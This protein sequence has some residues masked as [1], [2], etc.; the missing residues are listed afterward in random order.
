MLKA[1]LWS[2]TFYKLWLWGRVVPLALIPH[3]LTSNFFFNKFISKYKTCSYMCFAPAF[4]L[5]SCLINLTNIFKSLDEHL[6]RN[7]EIH[8]IKFDVCISHIFKACSHFMM[9]QILL[10][11]KL[12]QCT[13]NWKILLMNQFNL[14]ICTNM[15]LK[16]VF[17][18]GIKCF[19]FIIVSLLPEKN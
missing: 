17:Q 7:Y 3:L 13:I 6:K 10:I 16:N 18:L 9:T 5:K 14:I 15:Y 4:I 8:E 2:F 1:I 11:W 19:G 12:M